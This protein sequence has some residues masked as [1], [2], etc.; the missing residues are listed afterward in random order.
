MCGWD[1]WVSYGCNGRQTPPQL[2]L[3][4]GFLNLIL[5]QQLS[6]C[7]STVQLSFSVHGSPSFLMRPAG[8]EGEPLLC[9]ALVPEKLLGLLL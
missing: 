4:D 5:L 8:F 2:N 6:C 3:L 7:T 1:G 9:L